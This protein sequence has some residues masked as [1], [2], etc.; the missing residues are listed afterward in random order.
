MLVALMIIIALIILGTIFMVASKN[1]ISTSK[2]RVDEAYS[3]MDVYLK[4]RHDLIPN[5]VNTVKGYTN[6]E[7][8]T[9]ESI[10]KASNAALGANSRQ[11]A[12]NGEEKLDNVSTQLL[13]I[14]QAY[15]D[16]KA[17]S[18]FNNLMNQLQNVEEE[19]A[20]SRKYYNASVRIYNDRITTFPSKMFASHEELLPYF[21]VTSESERENVNVNF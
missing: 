9:L 8:D 3:T 18:S 5:L 4:K 15:P 14:A 11:Q 12:F 21:Q 2:N 20:N 13:A 6:Y 7:S 10:S 1:S 19:I 17:D 16:L